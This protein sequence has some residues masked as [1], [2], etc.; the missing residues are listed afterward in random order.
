MNFQI[1]GLLLN[2]SGDVLIATTALMVHRR[3][4]QTHKITSR[5]VQR[6]FSYEEIVG[7][8]GVVCVIVGAA[9]QA[10]AIS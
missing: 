9:L 5:K 8:L 6:A 1:I 7:S 2:T 4:H 10:Y 3:M